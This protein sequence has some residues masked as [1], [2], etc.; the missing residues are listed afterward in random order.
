MKRFIFVGIT[1]FLSLSTALAQSWQVP[2]NTIP[3]GKGPGKVGFGSIANTGAGDLCLLNT[4][5]PSFGACSGSLP[6]L[7]SSQ[8]F[9]GNGSNVAT[10]RTLS[11]TGWTCA[12]SSVGVLNCTT[13]QPYTGAVA[14]TISSKL[15]DFV[16]VADFGAVG[17]GSDESAKIQ[18]AIDAMA[19]LSNGGRVVLNC[20]TYTVGTTV[21]VKNGVSLS[22]LCDG[23]QR[24][25]VSSKATTT[26]K[27]TGGGAGPVLKTENQYF[28]IIENIFINANFGAQVGIWTANPQSAT[29]RNL[30]V[31]AI[32]AGS[33][34]GFNATGWYWEAISGSSSARNTLIDV[35]VETFNTGI[36]GMVLKGNMTAGACDA[37]ITHNTFINLFLGP[38][39]GG[40]GLKAVQCVDSNSF[41][42]PQIGAAG[43]GGVGVALLMPSLVDGTYG[44]NFYSGA[45]VSDAS[46]TSITAQNNVAQ[47]NFRDVY[48]LCCGTVYTDLGNG[49]IVRNGADVLGFT[50]D[51]TTNADMFP[52]FSPIGVGATLAYGN[53][54]SSS[55]KLKYNPSTGK[56]TSPT[57][58]ITGATALASAGGNVGIGTSS[59]S[60]QLHTT[61][62]VR[63]GGISGVGTSGCLGND[64][65][66]N[67]TGGNPCSG[68]GFPS[69]GVKGDLPYYS[70]A[71]TGAA[72]E[73]SDANV[74]IFG[75]DPTGVSSS[76]AAAVLAY[77]YSKRVIFP[78]APGG[79][80]GT[81]KFSTNITFPT[82]TELIIPCGVTLAPDSG[83]FVRNLGV[84]KADYCNIVSGAG[85]VS[86]GRD[87]KADWWPSTGGDDTLAINAADKSTNNA[88]A[89][90]FTGSISTTTL[91]VT[92]VAS[93]YITLGKPITGAGVTAGTI[94]TA[95]GTGTGETGTYTVSASQ[96]VGS[97]A[98]TGD[99]A[100]GSDN[101]IRLGCRTHTIATAIILHAN[102]ANPQKLVGCGP[103][104]TILS[105]SG[106]S[107]SRGAL[108]QAGTVAGVG[109]D[110][111]SFTWRDFSVACS[112]DQNIQGITLGTTT[113]AI[114]SYTKN[115]IERVRVTE[116]RTG[117]G[118]YN[119]RLVDLIDMWINV[120]GETTAAATVIQMDFDDNSQ[121]DGDSDIIRGQFACNLTSPSGGAGY[122]LRLKSERSGS[123]ISGIRVH[124]AV[125]YYCNKMVYGTWASTGTMG[126]HFF[127]AGLQCET[128]G[129]I[130]DY[131]GSTGTKK[132]A[133]LRFDG[134]YVTGTTGQPNFRFAGGNT[135]EIVDILVNNV[136]V[137]GGGG[138]GGCRFAS[139]EYTANSTITGNQMISF[140]GTGGNPNEIINL[141]ASR[142]STITNNTVD[143][144]GISGAVANLVT[145]G[146]SSSDVMIVGNNA[147][148]AVTALLNAS[149]VTN[150]CKSSNMPTS[151][152]D[153]NG[154]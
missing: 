106:G 11:G 116:C 20:K 10:A 62:T 124:G 40:T 127:G 81:Y 25:L 60:A 118:W 140:E 145:A 23:G 55:T 126:D 78:P 54:K 3:V 69:G 59:P 142:K 128:C 39:S 41:Y 96:T 119:T 150:V 49:N 132:A 72:T 44:N 109:N 13:I 4:A 17:D 125:F 90:S 115:V 18:A 89:L 139:L 14:R 12:L 97:E 135:D 75:G 154:C 93:G 137:R 46:A 74:I 153:A 21:T 79:T 84:T 29:F 47:N 101:I 82:G 64:T 92:A 129:N 123:N 53:V 35:V 26:L 104:A 146:T 1:F 6:A 30:S 152:I 68:T 122:G 138:C 95:F 91:T 94:I 120:H 50:N 130:A 57:L 105:A 48:L 134:I 7:P 63:F 151:A 37:P 32:G 148:A 33:S 121:F 111:M 77:G 15:L 36:D 143:A 31:Q 149:S 86:L 28:G 114:R 27:W 100:D 141:T 70:A 67:I 65:S 5:P 51:G 19:A 9:V 99:S 80:T 102:S 88:A 71:G 107:F 85:V 42:N 24:V 113:N 133:M 8:I 22:G 43:V 61:S 56:I 76:T 131:S 38:S 52:L 66:G 34:L 87:V 45:I 147:R 58:E 73:A 108:T 103:N 136:R 83:K 144:D 110:L 16:N 2:L 98:M 112:A 117:I